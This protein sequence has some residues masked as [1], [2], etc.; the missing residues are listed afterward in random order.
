M[1]A[2]GPLTGLRVVELTTSWAGPMAGRVFA[3]LGA[4]VIRIEPASRP[5]GWR[6]QGDV[7][8]TFRYP[9]SEPGERPWDRCA[10][11]NS[12]NVGKLDVALDLKLPGGREA[13]L[14]LIAK[15]DIVFCNFTPGTLTRLGLDHAHLSQIR[16]DIIVVEM[17]GYGSFGPMA[18]A[19]ALGP[20]IETASG[21]AS[22][23]GYRNGGPPTYTGP[24]YMDPTGGFHGA[25]AA[26]TALAYRRATGRGQHVE[27][28]Q[29]EAAMHYAGAEM[30]HAI[31][32]G[33]DI[34]RTGN[35][36]DWAVPHDT[37]PARGEDQWLVI[38]CLTEAQWIA[39]R[40]V[41]G[42]A[43]LAAEQ[44]ATLAGR[45][46]AQDEL[47]AII[48]EWT[49]P[50]DKLEAATLL[51]A[52]GVPAAPVQQAN[53]ALASPYLA[54]R[55]FF[56]DITHPDAGTH[57]HQGLSFHFSKSF[58]GP[59]TP[60]PCLG[61]HTEAVLRDLLG[62]TYAEIEALAAAGTTANVPPASAA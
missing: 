24:S 34:A 22:M 59:T 11:F 53:D 16:P 41:I 30:L 14:R 25:A 56:A 43:R 29:V 20:T 2:L 7:H 10:L 50:R 39:L 61:E 3:W 40:Q 23:I 46:A 26:L 8:A 47:G 31:A 5:C 17:P 62:M 18:N 58:A 4:E 33:R 6:H 32:T 35:R 57:P 54:A 19:T 42:D 9:N 12:Q 27:V 48:A 21:M 44:F 52:A 55:G 1:T 15:T 51:Q 45:L 13:L 38:A 28:P 36:V 49:R 37:F 60:A